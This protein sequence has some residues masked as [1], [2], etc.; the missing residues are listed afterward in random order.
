MAQGADG[1]PGAEIGYLVPDRFVHGYGLSPSVVELA[2]T[3]SPDLI[4]TV[5]NGIASVEGV[6]RAHELGIAV[7]VTDHHLP[8]ET[9]PDAECIVNPTSP[10]A[11]SSRSASPASA[12]CST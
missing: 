12:S 1:K 4:V 2:A 5:D 11:V 8:G 9:L 3:M 10:A 7:L 6:A